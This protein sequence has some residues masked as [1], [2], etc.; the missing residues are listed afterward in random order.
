M[1]DSLTIIV[2]EIYNKDVQLVIGTAQFGSLYGA[3]NKNIIDKKSSN[4]ILNFCKKNFLTEIDTAIDYHNSENLL[5]E[6]G[7][8]NFKVSTKLPKITKDKAKIEKWI[9]NEVDKSLSRLNIKN[10]ETLYLHEA[11]D[12]LSQHSQVIFETLN[13]LKKEKIIKKIG[14]SFYNPHDLINTLKNYK[15]DAVQVPLNVMD[16]RFINNHIINK[17]KD[18]SVTVYLRSIFLQGI[19]I[20]PHIN[21]PVYFKKWENYFKKWELWLAENNLNA[22]DTCINYAASKIKDSKIIIGISSLENLKEIN[23]F[24]RKEIPNIPNKYVCDDIKLID[25]RNWNIDE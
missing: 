14:V 10:L 12:L 7:M 15:I 8:L 18:E 23:C 1:L 11:K 3:T 19:L 9:H 22:V 24:K 21:H 16:S 4:E 6:F 17:L 5:G 13:N 25:P 2:S 20:T